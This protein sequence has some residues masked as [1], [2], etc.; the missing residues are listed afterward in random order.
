MIEQRYSR[1]GAMFAAGVV[2]GLG[3]DRA[4]EGALP[5]LVDLTS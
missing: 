2:Q 1:I 3:S 5:S 4:G